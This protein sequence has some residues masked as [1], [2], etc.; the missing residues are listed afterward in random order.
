MLGDAS[1]GD[2][3]DVP[4]LARLP[5]HASLAEADDATPSIFAAD[6]PLRRRA[7]DLVERVVDGVGRVNRRAVASAS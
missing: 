7:T 3:L 2:A 5:F 1:P 4:V 6:G